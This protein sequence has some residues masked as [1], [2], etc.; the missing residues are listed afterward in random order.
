VI[1]QGF[2]ASQN[3]L[4]RGLAAADSGAE[5]SVETGALVHGDWAVKGRLRD[6]GIQRGGGLRVGNR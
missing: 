1:F 6:D 4:I 5:M 2:G 3:V